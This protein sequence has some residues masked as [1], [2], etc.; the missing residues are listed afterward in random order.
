[1]LL[2]TKPCP[3]CGR[4]YVQ[5]VRIDREGNLTFIRPADWSTWNCRLLCI[6]CHKL[7]PERATF[8]EAQAE[9]N[10][11]TQCPG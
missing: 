1:M 5:P 4:T 7:G 9:W 11:V 8:E 2:G 10:G 6:H 3:R